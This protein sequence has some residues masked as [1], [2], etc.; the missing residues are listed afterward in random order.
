MN[1]MAEVLKG[2]PV[3]EAIK[4]K[5]NIE[6]QDLQKQ[7]VT[8]TLATVRVGNLPDDVA[9]E[10]SLTKKCRAM[11]IGVNNIVLDENVSQRELDETILSL[12][13]ADNVH[14]I[15]VFLPLPGHLNKD[16]ARNLIDPKKDVDGVTDISLSGV[17]S[18][19]NRGYS[20]CTAQAILEILNYYGIELRGKKIAVIGRSLVVGR[21]AAMLLMKENATVTIC[22]TGT[23]D[24]PSITK[25]ADIIVSAA[26]Q[27]RL[28]DSDFINNGQ[29]VI[30]AGT[31]WDEEKQGISGDVDFHKV[32]PLV[33]SITPVP[34]G[35][36][37]V[38]GTVLMAHVVDAA[39]PV[40]GNE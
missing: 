12:N 18:G 39:K 38:T 13:D 40:M 4:E 31:N 16:T 22:H 29:I 20:P 35:V 32:E 21:P 26:G 7:G 34:G 10:T 19:A 37:V 11:G 33:K 27:L 23:D 2:A 5:L 25:G 3:A 14:G 30:D 1:S 9:Y 8:P 6:I 24:I 17:Y 15:L 28:I 36:G